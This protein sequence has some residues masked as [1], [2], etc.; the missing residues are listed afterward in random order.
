MKYGC[1]GEKLG[2]SFSKEIHS[3]LNDYS[4]ELKELKPE[5]L[6]GFLLDKDFLGI[7][8]TI[9]Y[10][11]KV[12]PYLDFIDDSAT[13]IGA[14]NTIICKG[15]KL[16][17]YNTDFGGLKGL[18][19]KA[20]IDLKDK[21]VLILGTGGTSKTAVSVASALG[22]NKVLRV[23]RT[24]REDSVSYREVYEKHIDSDLIINTTPVGMF[25]NVDETP[26]DLTRFNN[27]SGVVDVVY[28]PLKTKL[29]ESAEKLNIKAVNGLY[30]L[31]LQAALA[32]EKFVETNYS[33]EEIDD[34]F[35]KITEIK[36]RENNK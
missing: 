31:V 5:E 29:V 36:E 30:M 4:Y 7:N 17:G 8:V 13:Y 35:E 16:Y 22:A 19:E 6:D 1:I 28:N 27:L 32:S 26:I 3:C 18:I 25:P 21:K 23:S 34:V 20:D 15:G 10:K 12:I 14:V 11:E 2:H 9:P 33:K 24:K